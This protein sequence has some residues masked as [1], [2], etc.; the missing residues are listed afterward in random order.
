MNVD[1]AKLRAPF[2]P[3][4]I[5][6]R[7]GSTNGDKTRG[8]ALAYITARHVQN[9]LD[10]AAGP[11]NWQTRYEFHG[12]RTVCYLSIRIGDDWV[13]KADGAGDSDVEAEKGSIS[14]AMKRAAVQ[15]GVGRY[16]YDIESTWVALKQQGR[17][18]VIA[19][20]EY[21][22]LEK[23]LPGAK[24]QNQPEPATPATPFDSTPQAKPKAQSRDA[25]TRLQSAFRA[26]A[27]RGLE[28]LWA[29][30]N[31]NTAD[32]MALPADWRDDL[33][34]AIILDGINVCASVDELKGWWTSWGQNMKA[35]SSPRMAELVAAKDAARTRLTPSE[36]A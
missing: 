24:V 9:R 20:G 28:D 32:V 16:L 10:E 6:W 36:A 15:W 11:E 34:K 21:A 23:I 22:R 30:W 5:E 8:L 7:V 19:E 27:E 31:D 12:S 25:F 35:M 2:A 4:D 18:Y 14:D 33:V 13:T 17:T 1:L 3:K 26:A 29:C